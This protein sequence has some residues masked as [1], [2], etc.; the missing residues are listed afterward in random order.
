MRER[1]ERLTLW[2][3]CLPSTPRL[4]RS[5]CC[6]TCRTWRS[7]A[8]WRPP[9]RSARPRCYSSSYSPAV[10]AEAGSSWP[11]LPPSEAGR[12]CCCCCCPRC[13]ESS[14]SSCSPASGGASERERRVSMGGPSQGEGNGADEASRGTQSA[15]VRMS[16]RWYGEAVS[17]MEGRKDTQKGPNGLETRNLPWRDTAV[18]ST[19]CPRATAR[20]DSSAAKERRSM[21]VWRGTSEPFASLFRPSGPRCER[22]GAGDPPSPAGATFSPPRP[23]FAQAVGRPRRGVGGNDRSPL[24]FFTSTHPTPPPFPAHTVPGPYSEARPGSFPAS[25]SA[26]FARATAPPPPSCG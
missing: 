18:L 26:R 16:G 21:S 9:G 10:L 4:S 6:H 23:P 5:P 1:V 22:N 11:S 14:P 7:D 15:C 19:A 12:C 8:A 3:K 13:R 24:T 2:G 17:E 20:E 25:H